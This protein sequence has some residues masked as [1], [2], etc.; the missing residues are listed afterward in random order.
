MKLRSEGRAWDDARTGR[1]A[2]PGNDQ[3]SAGHTALNRQRRLS[4]WRL[5][6]ALT[7]RNLGAC[8]AVEMLSAE[9]S[10]VR[11]TQVGPQAQWPCRDHFEGRNEGKTVPE[12]VNGVSSS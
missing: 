1:Y 9:W 11:S 3:P 5:S 10:N 4:P 2:P 12:G 6:S 8:C 7:L